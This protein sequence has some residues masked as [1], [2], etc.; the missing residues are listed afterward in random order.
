MVTTDYKLFTPLPIGKD[1]VLKNRVVMGPMG[2][3]R[4][5]KDSR[6]P[7]D[8]NVQ[9]Y[10]ERAGAGLIVSEATPVSSQ[11][12]GWLGSPALYTQEHAAGWKKVVDR[13]HA[14]GGKIFLQIWH[15]GRQAHSSFSPEAPEVVS[16]SAIGITS[17]HTRNNKGEEVPYEV[18]RA[19]ETAEI[20]GIIDDYR[21]S[22]TL[23][24]QVGFDGVEIHG[25][26]G[27]LVDQ[28]L[29]SATNKRT[30]QYGGSIENRARF[31]LEL[32]EALKTV[33]PS[34]RIAVRLSP[35]GAFAGMGSED[36]VETFIYV[37]Q[38][39][40]QLDLAYVA[41]LDGFGFGYHDKA[42]L[43]T[44]YDIKSHYKGTVIAA[45]SYTRD[46]AEGAIR[47]GAADAVCF[48]RPYISNPDL[49]ERF[50]NDWPLNPDASYADFWDSS[51]G[52]EGY[53]TFPAYATPKATK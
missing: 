17:G 30:D 44:A 11:G 39:L 10:G 2:R 25:G 37:L 1:L 7:N 18:P 53:T 43:M 19:L 36:N 49:A 22:A 4:T 47:S 27:Y 32:I 13:V 9:Y 31:L 35:N 38:Q 50:Q 23:A 8:L 12:Y 26:N 24:K 29:Q 41:I 45:N 52:A 15:M 21:K 5:D 33:W 14:N 48:A 16:A 51:R 46:I 6:A 28:F 40:S 42:P 20:A 34:D 3:A